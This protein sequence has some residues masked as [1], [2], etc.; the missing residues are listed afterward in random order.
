MPGVYY[1]LGLV[2][3]SQSSRLESVSQLSRVESRRVSRVLQST[4]FSRVESSPVSRGL[5]TRI[6]QL[7]P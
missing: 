6:E 1:G 3:S 7:R 2:D 4:D 5:H